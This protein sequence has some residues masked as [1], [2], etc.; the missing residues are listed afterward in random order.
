MKKLKVS[1]LRKLPVR[2][3]NKESIYD[4]ILVIPSG[5]KHESGWALMMIIG[6]NQNTPLE[7]AA[8]CDDIHWHIPEKLDY[9]LR[10]DMYYPSGIIKYWSN[11]YK[12][13]VGTSLSST[14]V[15][16]TNN[17]QPDEQH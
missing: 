12:F 5:K 9:D 1:E 6:M 3:W 7:I 4:S 17:P 2:D 16:L 8:M 11:R 13:K 15:Y 10:N 14:D